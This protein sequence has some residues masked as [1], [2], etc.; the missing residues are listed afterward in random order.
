MLNRW[1]CDSLAFAPRKWMRRLFTAA[2]LA[3][4]PVFY[5]GSPATMSHFGQYSRWLFLDE[6]AA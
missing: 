2:V 1:L 4:N 3:P 6:K 5:G